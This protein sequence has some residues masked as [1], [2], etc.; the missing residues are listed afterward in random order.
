MNICVTLSEKWIGIFFSG[1]GKDFISFTFKLC[2]RIRHPKDLT[3][4][5][6]WLTNAWTDLAMANYPYPASFLEPLP[7]WPVKVYDNVL[8]R[9]HTC[10]FICR[11]VHFMSSTLNIVEA[12]IFMCV[13]VCVYMCV[14]ACGCVC[15]H[16]G[17]CFTSNIKC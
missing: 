4:L 5:K 6:A 1:E 17:L 13:C 14:R 3:N 16:V 15:M 11:L 12:Y 10:H 9:Y 7:G 2:E 8:H